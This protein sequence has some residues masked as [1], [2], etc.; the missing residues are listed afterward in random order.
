MTKIV[1]VDKNKNKKET[2]LR[3][4]NLETLFK[5]ANLKNNKNFLNRKTWKVNNNY[6][7]IYAKDTG[8]ANNEIL[9]S[10]L[11]QLILNYILEI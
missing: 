5:K 10:C 6:V 8:R 1:I 2:N 7:S 11:H 4:F 3:E 9:M